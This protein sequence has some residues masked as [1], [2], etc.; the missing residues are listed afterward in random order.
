M[1]PEATVNTLRCVFVG[2][3]VVGVAVV[4]LA[5]NRLIQIWKVGNL[6]SGLSDAAH[7]I[8]KEVFNK[9]K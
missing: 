8:Q 9:N 7:S 5:I 4:S 3:G 6:S 2:G 1:N